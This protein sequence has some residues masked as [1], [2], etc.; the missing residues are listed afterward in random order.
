MYIGKYTRGGQ[1]SRPCASQLKTGTRKD[2]LLN[3]LKLN[4]K[5]LKIN[6]RQIH[7]YDLQLEIKGR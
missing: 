5:L 6:N 7:S 2:L 3:P 4:T 1:Y